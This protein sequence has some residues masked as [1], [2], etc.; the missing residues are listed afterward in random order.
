MQCNDFYQRT[1]FLTSIASIYKITY[2]YRK[3]YDQRLM[4]N[5]N[6]RVIHTWKY[7]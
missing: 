4:K 6:N 3:E 2:F 7:F 1:I 5:G